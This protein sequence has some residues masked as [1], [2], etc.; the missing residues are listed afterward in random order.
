M[1]I[2]TGYWVFCVNSSIISKTVNRPSLDDESRRGDC[3]RSASIDLKCCI[4]AQLT[5]S[6]DYWIEDGYLRPFQHASEDSESTV[7]SVL[8]TIRRSNFLTEMIGVLASILPIQWFHGLDFGHSPILAV[9]PILQF[10]NYSDY[11]LAIQILRLYDYSPILTILS[12]KAQWIW[13][14]FALKVLITKTHYPSSS[15][16]SYPKNCTQEFESA[17]A[18]EGS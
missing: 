17:C 9:L 16:K 6:C 3:S 8:W 14:L 13:L 4:P 7:V 11:S 1:A 15:W 5:E 10:H 2:Y 18:I 12:R